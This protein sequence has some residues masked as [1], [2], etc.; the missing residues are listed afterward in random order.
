MPCCSPSAWTPI[1]GHQRERDHLL[2]ALSAT[3]SIASSSPR[4][5]MSPISL[6]RSAKVLEPAAQQR[7]PCAPRCPSGRARPARP[8]PRRDRAGERVGEIG[9]PC[10]NPPAP[11]TA[12]AMCAGASRRPSACSRRRALRE[13][14]QVRL[15]LRPVMGGQELAGAARRRRSP[16]R[17]SAGSPCRSQ[18]SR[19]AR[20][21]GSGGTQRARSPSPPIGSTMKASTVSGPSARMSVSSASRQ[22]RA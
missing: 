11:A 18:I 10:A 12:S 21:Y 7:R 19:T 3:I 13:H 8:A 2:V 4:P 16:R 14:D 20:K 22:W 17:R 1:G 6:V 5:R 15:G 9:E